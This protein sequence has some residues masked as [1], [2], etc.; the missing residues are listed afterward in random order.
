MS[1]GHK[2]VVFPHFVGPEPASNDSQRLVYSCYQVFHLLAIAHVFSLEKNLLLFYI[3]IKKRISVI[4]T[5][6][7]RKVTDTNMAP[8]L[9]LEHN[10]H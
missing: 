2:N 8:A 9:F 3:E 6:A 5:S 7:L 1:K 10:E 4:G